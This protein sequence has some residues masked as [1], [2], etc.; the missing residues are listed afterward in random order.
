[1]ELIFFTKFLKGLSAKEV[2]RT[3][4]D[5]GFDGL[6]LAIRGGQCVDPAN[7]ATAT[8]THSPAPHSQITRWI[9]HIPANQM[10]A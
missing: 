6:D 8:T 9:Y 10:S 1:M 4:K 5:L 3:V 2:G 7:V